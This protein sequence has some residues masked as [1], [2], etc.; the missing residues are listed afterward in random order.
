MYLFAGK[1]QESEENMS[2]CTLFIVSEVFVF[3]LRIHEENEIMWHV[4][5]WSKEAVIFNSKRIENTWKFDILARIT[6]KKI[7]V[8]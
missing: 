4:K 2:R 7:K 6:R 8:T 5:T 1:T 3:V